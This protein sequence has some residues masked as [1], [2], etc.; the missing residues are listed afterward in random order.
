M[1]DATFKCGRRS[2]A[3]LDSSLLTE[4]ESSL[5]SLSL[6]TPCIV[7]KHLVPRLLH[8]RHRTWRAWVGYEWPALTWCR[9]PKLDLSTWPSMK[10]AW[11]LPFQVKSSWHVFPS[12]KY[13]RQTWTRGNQYLSLSMLKNWVKHFP[14]SKVHPRALTERGTFDILLIYFSGT[15]SVNYGIHVRRVVL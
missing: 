12:L 3:E 14:P 15:V 10:R 11:R 7:N 6:L 1:C 4:L 9:L 2:C 5:C 13:L 8:A